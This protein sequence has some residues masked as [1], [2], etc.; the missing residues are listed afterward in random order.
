MNTTSSS[1]GSY[2][3]HFRISPV[4]IPKLTTHGKLYVNSEA[5]EGIKAHS[6]DAITAVTAME[7]SKRLHYF[8]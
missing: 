1:P 2:N 5:G 8:L 4:M 6:H 3:D 7:S